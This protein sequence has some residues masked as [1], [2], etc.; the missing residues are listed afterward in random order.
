MTRP[1]LA[2]VV[3]ALVILGLC[4]L[5]VLATSASAIAAQDAPAEAETPSVAESGDACGAAPGLIGGVCDSVGDL[6]I[7]GV[8][9]IV[10]G[11]ADAVLRSMVSFVVEG[12]GWLLGQLVGFIDTSTRPDLTSGW[13][14][15]AYA[16]M[17]II[18][19]FGV[20]P[21]LLL[22]VIHALV[23]QDL[24][25]MLRAAFGYIPLA[26]IGTAGAVVVVD[27]LVEMT[28]GLSSWVGRGLGTDLSSFATGVGTALARVSAP[29]GSSVAGF[30][31]LIGGAVVAFASFVIWLELLLRQAAI[32]VAVLFFP[33]G[34]MAMVWPATAHWVRRLAQGLL[35]IILSKFVI[36]TV[37]ALAASALDAEVADEGFGVVMAGGSLLALAALSPYVLLRLIPVFDAGMSSQLEGTFRR[38]TAAVGTPVHG[39]QIS[40]M[41]RQGV[42]GQSAGGGAGVGGSGSAAAGTAGGGASM[43]AGTA[44][45][46]ASLVAAGVAGAGRAA[47]RSAKSSATGTANVASASTGHGPATSRP[48]PKRASPMPSQPNG[49]DSSSSGSDGRKA[50]R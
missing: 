7:G 17:A 44:T 19:A 41:V 40:R 3:R 16:D 21:F 4:L 22:A 45:A 18:G 6:L 47:V 36:V 50:S 8:G 35:A 29:T 5:A 9:T 46:G 30:A 34:F 14:Q 32:Y 38:P 12:A 49:P 26:A 28:D 27:L 33:L 2:A 24:S 23:R 11:G 13:F 25:M 39:G 37:M 1:I 43:A 31:A 48:S 15:A 20:L 10:G 42:R